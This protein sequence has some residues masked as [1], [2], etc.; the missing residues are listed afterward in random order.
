M[1]IPIYQIDAF[2]DQLFKGNPA[3][4]CLLESWP[5]DHILQSIAAENNLSETAFCLPENKHFALRW[6]TPQ[7][8]IDLCGHAT[9]ASAYV[10]MKY[11]DS[12]LKKVSFETKS[13]ILS[14]E[15]ENDLL[16]M[17][18]PARPAS[19]SQAPPEL[20][21]GLGMQPQEVF[22]SRDYLVVF[23][24]EAIVRDLIPDMRLLEQVDC[25]G[26]IVT[27]PG[28][29]TDFVSRFFAPKV[30]IP[31]DPVTGSSH[32]T[33]IPYWAERL[34]K[35]R[36]TA[37]QL[38]ERGGALVCEDRNGRVKIAGKGVAYLE[39]MINI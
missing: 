13:G 9:L 4:V 33:L 10:I 32:C 24:N 38:S 19:P 20:L 22:R 31:E 30:G 11:V 21:K 23:D 14:V 29:T 2:T 34:G 35:S 17:D 15:R 26:V 37:A 12:S 3:A 28:D 7:A 6:F 39:G 25:T 27:A 1:R 8:E 5:E 18:F 16:A 36:L